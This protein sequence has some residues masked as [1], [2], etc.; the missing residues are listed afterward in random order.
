MLYE[1]IAVVR[2]GR[3]TD[4]KELVRSTGQ[5]ILSQRGVIRSIANW[6]TYLL[7][8][9]INRRT[10]RYTEGHHFIMRF[11]CAPSTQDAVKRMLGVDPRMLKFGVVKVGDGTLGGM[12][13]K[14]GVNWT[15]LE[16]GESRNSS[17]R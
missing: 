6:G 1:L 15:R 7:T 17:Y 8:K 9:P 13:D 10:A 5:I 12:M 14:A 4:V 11:D 2:P 16:E 3:V